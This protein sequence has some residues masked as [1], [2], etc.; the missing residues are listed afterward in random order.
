MNE[1]EEETLHVREETEGKVEDV[2]FESSGLQSR[3]DASALQLPHASNRLTLEHELPNPDWGG[4]RALIRSS[5]R[6]F[7]LQ[8]LFLLVQ[9]LA[10]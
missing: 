2:F 10:W 7:R 5:S 1:K 4:L 3:P 6:F 8:F 9:L